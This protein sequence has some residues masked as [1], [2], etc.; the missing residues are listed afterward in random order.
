MSSVVDSFG[1]RDELS[2]DQVV[3]GVDTDLTLCVQS[4]Q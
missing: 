2:M 4:G 1:G 3:M